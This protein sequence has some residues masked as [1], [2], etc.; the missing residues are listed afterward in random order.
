M[1]DV[2]RSPFLF[3]IAP[4]G[5]YRAASFTSRA[6]R[7]Y[8]TLSPLPH[9]PKAVG[10]LLSVALSLSPLPDPPDVIR[11]PVTLEP[12]LSSALKRRDH[13]AR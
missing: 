9:K 5:V 1:A 7:S 4:D 6:V 2:T 3:D 13:P 12:G 10:G 8:R 11:H